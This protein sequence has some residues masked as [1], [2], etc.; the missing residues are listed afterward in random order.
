MHLLFTDRLLRSLEGTD[1]SAFDPNAAAASPTDPAQ[2]ENL[3]R[4]ILWMKEKYEQYRDLADQRIEILKDELARAEKKYQDLLDKRMAEDPGQLP[5]LYA[6]AKQ[7]LEEKDR[8]IEELVARLQ[9]SSQL[10]LNISKELDRSVPNQLSPSFDPPSAAP[11]PANVAAH[12]DHPATIGQPEPA[13]VF[14]PQS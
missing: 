10:L 7:K 8:Q 12:P 13:P 1:H 9:N 11:G 5:T 4:G 2:N 6:A 14:N 3:Y